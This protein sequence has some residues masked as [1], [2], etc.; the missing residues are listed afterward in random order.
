M[1]M[2]KDSTV[3]GVIFLQYLKQ[4]SS[5]EEARI[6]TTTKKLPRSKKSIV[7]P[8]DSVSIIINYNRKKSQ[9]DLLSRMME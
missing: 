8:I 4:K 1:S 3:R 6:L 2:E 7:S 5:T 9:I